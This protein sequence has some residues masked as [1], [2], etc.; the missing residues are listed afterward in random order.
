M[1]EGG[2]EPSSA[3]EEAVV[4]SDGDQLGEVEELGGR[5]LDD[6]QQLGCL[7]VARRRL[8]VRPALQT[9]RPV[10]I[11]DAD[12][13]LRGRRAVN[14]AGRDAMPSKADL[15]VDLSLNG[16]WASDSGRH[17]TALRSGPCGLRRH[18][19]LSSPG[20]GGGLGRRRRR[21]DEAVAMRLR[22]RAWRWSPR[23]ERWSG[24]RRGGGRGSP[25]PSGAGCP[26]DSRSLE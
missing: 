25:A 4:R 21:V 20:R 15:S 11:P 24:V 3:D 10:E 2:D 6:P 5:P 23:G 13:R 26:N 12:R 14:T 16:C 7:D 17:C 18:V 1:T 22:R 19:M 9:Q 8:A